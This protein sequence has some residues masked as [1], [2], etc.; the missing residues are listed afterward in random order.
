MLHGVD[1][2]QRQEEGGNLKC[3]LC[4]KEYRNQATLTRH[5]NQKHGSGTE[6]RCAHCERVFKTKNTR[7]LHEKACEKNPERVVY[8]CE[9]CG[10][11]CDTDA[12]LRRHNKANHGEHG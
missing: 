11:E 6:F 9:F 4:G 12:K 2:I 7:T 3:D 1:E 10:R 8:T 5:T